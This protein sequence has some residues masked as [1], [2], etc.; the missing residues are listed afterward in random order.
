[1]AQTRVPGR[2]QQ[3]PWLKRQSCKSRKTEAAGI[4]RT[5]YQ[6]RESC[7]APGGL[8]T[9]SIQQETDHHVSARTGQDGPAGLDGAAA[10]AFPGPDGR[11]AQSSQ[12]SGKDPVSCP[13]GAGDLAP[14]KH[15]SDPA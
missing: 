7:P 2:T 5:G 9:L 11:K 13:R 1:M 3:T 14:E 15:S 6:R 8:G 12:V 10:R 4:P